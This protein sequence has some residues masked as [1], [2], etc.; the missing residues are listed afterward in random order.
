MTLLAI[1]LLV[2][3]LGSVLLV[4]TSSIITGKDLEDLNSPSEETS[5][6]S[7]LAYWG[8]R[9]TSHQ[10]P[11]TLMIVIPGFDSNVISSNL[12]LLSLFDSRIKNEGKKY[13]YF[14]SNQIIVNWISLL[15]GVPRYI[16][17][18]NSNNFSGQELYRYDNLISNLS[19]KGETSHF[20]VSPVIKEFLLISASGAKITSF[21]NNESLDENLINVFKTK[22]I[23]LD[24]L[25]VIQLTGLFDLM[26]NQIMDKGFIDLAD[27]SIQNKIRL[28]TAFI[29]DLM[30]LGDKYR[31]IITS[32]FKFDNSKIFTGGKSASL[33]NNTPFFIVQPSSNIGLNPLLMIYS[34]S[35]RPIFKL[36]DISASLSLLLGLNFNRANTGVLIEEL[37]LVL[38]YSDSDKAVTYFA[39]RNQAHHLFMKLLDKLEANTE[40]LKIYSNPGELTPN[41]HDAYLKD[42]TTFHNELTSVIT[43]KKEIVFAYNQ[44]IALVIIGSSLFIYLLIFQQMTFGDII[45]VLICHKPDPLNFSI[46]FIS[47]FIILLHL[48]ICDVISLVLLPFDFESLK[49]SFGRAALVMLFIPGSLYLFLTRLAF[50]KFYYPEKQNDLKNFKANFRSFNFFRN[51]V[52]CIYSENGL[53][54]IYLYRIY[55]QLNC[56]IILLVLLFA[57]SISSYPFTQNSVIVYYEKSAF[58]EEVNKVILRTLYYLGLIQLAN[59]CEYFNYPKFS[60]IKQVFDSIFML[61]DTKLMSSIYLEMSN[62]IEKQAL[63]SEFATKVV[64]VDPQ[65]SQF[66]ANSKM[67]GRLL[68][69]E[70]FSNSLAID[71]ILNMEFKLSRIDE[72]VLVENEIMGRNDLNITNELKSIF[73]RNK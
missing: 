3:Q 53:G 5:N 40:N 18:V 14:G 30:L 69:S 44:M 21:P 4:G 70:E 60:S 45:K 32:D 6:L 13:E 57:S 73:G 22:I 19:R 37:F 41:S 25:L 68:F 67:Q 52:N 59:I 29:N 47:I 42:I 64:N 24:K 2:S 27:E 62:T 55:V 63:E 35:N 58:F 65:S 36:E 39:L 51:S 23:D 28:Y 31:I 17:G 15:F 11:K 61:Y 26:S 56:F 12:I 66:I 10:I 71:N 48:I 1:Y 43:S 8:Q 49:N 34:E 9:Q 33:S 54:C 38:A 20:I 7:F 16:S 72:S 46:Y 50:S